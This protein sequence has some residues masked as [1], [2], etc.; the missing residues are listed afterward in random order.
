MAKYYRSN[1]RISYFI[2]AV[3]LHYL[4]H[5]NI[6]VSFYRLLYGTIFWARENIDENLALR[7][8]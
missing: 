5:F 8:I 4:W 1:R 3:I 7:K 6:I 2:R